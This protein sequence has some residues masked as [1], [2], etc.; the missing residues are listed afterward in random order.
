MSLR[1]LRPLRIH[2]RG[3]WDVGECTQRCKKKH[4]ITACLIIQHQGKYL[5]KTLRRFFLCAYFQK[6]IT[7][8]H[9]K[10]FKDLYLSAWHRDKT[11]EQN[12]PPQASVL[13]CTAVTACPVTQWSQTFHWEPDPC[14]QISCLVLWKGGLFV[15]IFF[16]WVK[17]SEDYVSLSYYIRTMP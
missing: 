16:N 14:S 5:L 2:L 17:F 13:P 15:I 3:W 9:T 1:Q 7:S 8:S 11:D 10:N 12:V 6:K 4:R